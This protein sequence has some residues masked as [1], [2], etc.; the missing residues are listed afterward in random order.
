MAFPFPR[1]MYNI[2]T[3]ERAGTRNKP[4]LVTLPNGESKECS[5]PQMTNPGKLTGL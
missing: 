4:L 5:A 3:I 1:T 2:G